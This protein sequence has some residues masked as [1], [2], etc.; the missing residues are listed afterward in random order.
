MVVLP[1]FILIG[2]QDLKFVASQQPWASS[3]TAARVGSPAVGPQNSKGRKRRTIW[4]FTDHCQPGDRRG[5]G[6]RG[7]N[8]GVSY[9]CIGTTGRG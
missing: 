2:S 7:Q 1:E 4:L 6:G 9:Y 3:V 8:N 5:V